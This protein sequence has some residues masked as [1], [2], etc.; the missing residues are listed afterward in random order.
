[1]GSSIYDE[2]LLFHEQ[3]RG[4][5]EV[6][7]KVPVKNRHDLSVAYTPGVAEVARKIAADPESAYRYTLKANTVAVVSDGSAVLGLGDVGGLRQ[8]RSWRERHFSLRILQGLIRFQSVLH[9]R[10][11]ISWRIS[12]ISLRYSAG[13]TWRISP[14]PGVLRLKLPS[15]ILVSRDA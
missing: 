1:M 4:K 8:F 3:H 13:S 2:S 7:G 6:R 14:L 15:R 10:M 12:E 5:I 11:L 9:Q